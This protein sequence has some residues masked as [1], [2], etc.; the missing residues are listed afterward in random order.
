[1]S[2]PVGEL[3]LY[4]FGAATP[5]RFRCSDAMCTGLQ[6]AE[7]WQDVGEDYGAGSDLPQEDLLR[8]G[9][10]EGDVAAADA[11]ASGFREL[12]AFEV[13]ARPRSLLDEGLPSS[14]PSGQI[15]LRHRRL[16]R[17]RAGR[18]R[19]G[20]GSGFDVLRRIPRAARG[21]TRGRSRPCAS[22]GRRP[23]AVDD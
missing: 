14:A 11:R 20:G 10:A 22:C 9:V 16:G 23:P 18:A 19:R 7:H 12:M 3:V 21:A 2:N 13:D 4:A 1:M 15:R 17:W 5:D 8:F 6:L